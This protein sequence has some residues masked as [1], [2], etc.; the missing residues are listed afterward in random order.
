MTSSKPYSYDYPMP[1]VCVDMVVFGRENSQWHVLLIERGK[2][3]WKGMWATPGGFVEIDETAESAAHRELEE[4]TGLKGIVLE[5][6]HTFSEV[7]RDPRGRVISVSFVGCIEKD[8]WVPVAGDDAAHVSW[9]PIDALPALAADHSNIIQ[10]AKE[11]LFLW[12]KAGH[13]ALGASF[14]HWNASSN[15][16]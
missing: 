7:D 10:K 11:M 8:L 2:E 6:F 14:Q 15:G 16:Q 4:E 9:F 13:Y 12:K 1:S 3:P 5:Q